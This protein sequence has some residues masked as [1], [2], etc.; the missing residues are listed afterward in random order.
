MIPK[1]IFFLCQM[2]YP[3]TFSQ[4]LIYRERGTQ[5]TR[6]ILLEDI[7][8]R[9]VLYSIYSIYSIYPFYNDNYY[10]IYSIALRY[11]IL[12]YFI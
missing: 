9:R 6:K 10:Y 5:Y 2:K 8:T 1:T 3:I 12:Q 4:N 7:Y 11:L